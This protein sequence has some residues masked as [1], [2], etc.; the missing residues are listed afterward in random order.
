MNIGDC[1]FSMP[2]CN[3][4]LV[5]L[6]PCESKWSDSNRGCDI[7]SAKMWFGDGFGPLATIIL[8]QN[9]VKWSC[10][11]GYG[12]SPKPKQIT[13]TTNQQKSFRDFNQ[14]RLRKI[15]LYAIKIL[16]L[17]KKWKIIIEIH[18]IY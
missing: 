15:I 14:R 6:H 3:L 9:Y 7:N 5:L 1:I 13:T 12:K 16:I 10:E 11:S 18:N 17:E 8:V 2:N 4:S